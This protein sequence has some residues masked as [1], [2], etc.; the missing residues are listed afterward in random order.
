MRVV[1]FFL[2]LCLCV[3]MKAQTTLKGN[4]V[5]WKNKIHLKLDLEHESV[6]V[7]GMEFLGMTNGYMNGDIYG[8]WMVTSSKVIDQQFVVKFTNDF[9]S[10]SQV[11]HF[12]LKNDSTL[13]YEAQEPTVIKKAV[14]R[15]LYKIP[16][17]LTFIR[18]K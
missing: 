15:K 1:G 12:T 7:P 16:S 13:L 3:G 10:E 9:G 6:L 14:K 5:D 18:Q 8:V 11:V 17:K 4:F 2:F